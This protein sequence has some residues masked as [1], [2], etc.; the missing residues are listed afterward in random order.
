MDESIAV[1]VPG[2]RI[3]DVQFD[4]ARHNVEAINHLSLHEMMIGLPQVT[5]VMPY[6]PVDMNVVLH[7]D[8]REK[9]M[10][11]YVQPIRSYKRLLALQL[12][13]AIAETRQVTDTANLFVVGDSSELSEVGYSAQVL[14]GTEHPEAAAEAVADI[15]RRGLTFVVS[16]FDQ[17]P[18]QS[19]NWFN[20]SRTV[21][22]KANH[23]FELE[24][25]AKVGAWPM[26]GLWEVDTHNK[27]H[28]RATNEDIARR[29]TV[30]AQQ[31]G[32]LGLQTAHVTYRNSSTE[33][34]NIADAD[35]QIA[36]SIREIGV[37]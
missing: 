28:L 10:N 26:G 25:P 3:A 16:N 9:R 29:Q 27:K 13:D 18:L 15:C 11:K 1:G 23:E 24:I 14:D 30:I 37:V 35:A 34:M 8:P 12:Q 31:L 5:E 7:Q 6:R 2:I 32:S 22:V 33:R 17:L 21:A 19:H 36:S 4:P 20:G